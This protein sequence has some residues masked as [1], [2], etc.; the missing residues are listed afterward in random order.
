MIEL[1]NIN[2]DEK[3][4]V[5]AVIQDVKTKE[6]L[7]V[8]YMN[9]E[10]L[11]KTIETKTAW[12]YSRKR[13]RLWQKGETSG[14]LLL[15]D[16]ILYDCD[17]DTLLLKVNPKGPTCHTGNKSCFYR[18][19]IQE[20]TTDNSSDSVDGQGDLTQII[21]ELIEIIDSRFTEKP[22]GSYI[23]KLYNGGKE[24]ILKKVGEEATE[25]VIASMSENKGDTIYETADLIFHLLIALRYDNISLSQVLAEL[26]RRRK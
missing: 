21:D 10:A 18:E 16:K 5:P 20:S 24:K 13:K 2:Y 7:M 4:L 22:E 26:R 9:K 14:N 17:K 19:L 25:V 23:V 8:A 3:G 15:V 11:E 6:V 12:F 1:D